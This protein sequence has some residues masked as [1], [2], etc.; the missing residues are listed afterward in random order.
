MDRIDSIIEEIKKI[1]WDDY[2]HEDNSVDLLGCEEYIN[3]MYV[4][5][6]QKKKNNELTICSNDS[7]EEF[8]CK[9]PGTEE[10]FFRI[11]KFIKSLSNVEVVPRLIISLYNIMN[12]RNKYG[13][14]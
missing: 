3:D 12:A 6:E 2:G 1:E 5:L 8:F 9:W 13:L 14:K 7:Y 10:E 11:W 4:Y